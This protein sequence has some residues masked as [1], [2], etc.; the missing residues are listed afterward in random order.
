[1]QM[2]ENYS[3]FVINSRMPLNEALNAYSDQISY[4]TLKDGTNIEVFQ[5][6]QNFRQR[7]EM[8]YNNQIQ[9]QN[10]YEFVEENIIETSPN[11]YYQ[12]TPMNY[13]GPFRG[14]GLKKSLGT[15]LRKTVLKSMTGKEPEANVP[16]EQ[17]LRYFNPNKGNKSLNDIITF[18][19]NNE[20]LQCA[21]CKKFFISDEKEDE[22]KDQTNNQPIQNENQN[23]NQKIPAQ[24]QQF[25]QVTPRKNDQKKNYQPYSGQQSPPP[26][27]FQPHQN[28]SQFYPQQGHP[29]QNQYHQNQMMPHNQ[30]QQ[31]NIQMGFPPMPNQYQ[32]QFYPQQGQH[33]QKQ[34][35][36]Y[37][38]QIPV[39]QQKQ[40]QRGVQKGYGVQGSYIAQNAPMSAQFRGQ[41]NYVF[42]ARKKEVNRYDSNNDR[43]INYTSEENYIY[44]GSNKKR[45]SNRKLVFECPIHK[46]MIHNTS[47]NNINRNLSYGFKK[48]YSNAPEIGYTDNNLSE[49]INANEMG[50]NNIGYYKYP[51]QERKYMIPTGYG[52]KKVNQKMVYVDMGNDEYNDY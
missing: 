27:Q 28:I 10:D 19:E 24:N 36:Q 5:D 35:Q 41:N 12:Q 4:I 34:P 48:S 2:E 40:N 43:Y 45:G 22:N 15:T 17:K 32:Q 3:P 11:A 13:P 1:M 51:Q 38:Q 16:S 29:S 23:Q 18:T 14:K 33:H 6:N 26:Q 31:Q 8:G 21:N 52:T 30:K 47:S 20:Y 49:Y 25:A 7:P 44:P 9:S 46:K 39:P 50:M 37:Y 42:R